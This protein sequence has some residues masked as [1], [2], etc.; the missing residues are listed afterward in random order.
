[1]SV[2]DAA[3]HL[4]HQV[5]CLLYPGHKDTRKKDRNNLENHPCSLFPIQLQEHTP[6]KD[7]KI[8]LVTTYSGFN[9]RVRAHLRWNPY[10][11]ASPG[12]LPPPAFK[13]TELYHATAGTSIATNCRVPYS[14]YSFGILCLKHT[15]G[16]CWQ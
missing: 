1:M 9:S 10:E 15:F 13:A 8:M 3:R 14:E 16:T 6:H 2:C 12:D 4:L 11:E 7:F 5:V